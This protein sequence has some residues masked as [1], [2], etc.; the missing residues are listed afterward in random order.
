[1]ATAK[2]GGHSCTFGT[3][4]THTTTFSPAEDVRCEIFNVVH[5]NYRVLE[6]AHWVAEVLAEHRGASIEVKRDRSVDAGARSYYVTGD[7]IANRLGF[8][9]DRGTSEAVLQIWDNLEA[10]VYGPEP[11]TDPKF[12]NIRWLQQ[13]VLH[14]NGTLKEAGVPV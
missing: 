6:L 9:A 5:K 14:S 1:M 10:G 11:E 7:K 4:L 13:Q 12:F 3:R 2:P 8:R